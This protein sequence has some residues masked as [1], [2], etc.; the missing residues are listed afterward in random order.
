MIAELLTPATVREE[1]RLFIE[2]LRL[3]AEQVE[4]TP[5][6]E[7]EI[8]FGLSPEALRAVAAAMEDEAAED[9]GE[10]D[11]GAYI[12]T[13][14]LTCLLQSYYEEQFRKR[15]WVT[16]PA[17]VRGL[18]MSEVAITNERLSRTATAARGLAVGG[19]EDGEDVRY[20]VDGMTGVLDRLF[21]GKAKF[22]PQPAA[23]AQLGNDARILLFGDWATGLPRAQALA[24]AMATEL[25][26]DQAGRSQHLIHLGDTY[27][28]GRSSEYKARFLPFWPKAGGSVQTQWSLNGNHDM[29]SGGDGYFKTL[30]TDGRFKSHRDAAGHP[31]SFFLLEN[32]HWQIF[33]LDSAFHSP[34]LTGMDGA[35]DQSQ[36]DFVAREIKPAK[37]VILLTHHQLF[38]ARKGEGN[39]RQIRN[40]L[41][42]RGVWKHV[43]GWI[44][45]HEHRGVLYAPAWAKSKHDLPFAIC[46]GNCGVPTEEKAGVVEP[47]AVEWEYVETMKSGTKRFMKFAFASLEFAAATPQ[48]VKV[49]FHRQDRTVAYEAAIHRNKA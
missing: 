19:F 27:Y 35:I 24:D 47:G 11:S 17:P 38:S 5:P 3:L 40:A 22:N 30:L 48:E 49:K 12:P 23:R 44:W 39:S 36:A 43:C 18:A 25:K 34:Q 10:R 26:G 9:T 31:S 45:G 14:P 1:R 41:V 8:G 2:R 16:S 20:I 13:A 4:K 46:L 32:D 21:T 42:T 29:Y 33:G 7:N 28:A 15:G 6:T 37:G